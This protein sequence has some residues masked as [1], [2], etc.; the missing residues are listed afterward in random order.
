M[1]SFPNLAFVKAESEAFLSLFSS[2]NAIS[3]L[4]SPLL[5]H[6]PLYDQYCKDHYADGHCDQGC[7]NAECE[8]D[9]LDCANN[10]PEKLAAGLLVVVVHIMPDQLRNN[11]FGFLRELS[12]VLHTNVVFRRDRKGEEMIY[13]YYG[14]EQ[15]LKK[16]NIKRSLDSWNDV[17]SNVMSSVKSSIYNIVVEGGRKRRELDEMQIKG[18]VCYNRALICFKNT[19]E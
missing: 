18:Y 1:C 19:F 5:S 9:G 7:N 13:P 8:W 15:E 12:R 16:H 2:F 14:N 6:S 3:K 4:C 17:S 11:S 10:I